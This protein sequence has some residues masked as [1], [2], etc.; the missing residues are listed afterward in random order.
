MIWAKKQGSYGSGEVRGYQGKAQITLEAVG[1]KVAACK[2]LEL[3]GFGQ[4]KKK[5]TSKN[6]SFF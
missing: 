1:E 3:D 2:E 4:K 5:K 6:K